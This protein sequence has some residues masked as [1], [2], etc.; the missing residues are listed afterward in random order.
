MN[1][2]PSSSFLESVPLLLC[3]GDSDERLLDRIFNTRELKAQQVGG[4]RNIRPA[5]AYLTR[6]NQPV[7]TIQDC[8]FRPL[9][10]AEECYSQNYAERHFMWRRHELENYLIEPR[11]VANCFKQLQPYSKV[12]L[13]DTEDSARHWIKNLAR[14]LLEDQAGRQTA[15]EL[16]RQLHN[17]FPTASSI[18][19]VNA[20]QNR[21]EWQNRL[22]N[23]M[24]EICS[25]AQQFGEF[26]QT[27]DADILQN[28]EANLQAFSE[29]NFLNIDGHL[30]DF[31]GREMVQKIHQEAY[32][33]VSRYGLREFQT[34][35]VESFVEEWNHDPSFLQPNDF[36]DLSAAI[37]RL[38]GASSR[39][40]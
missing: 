10:E 27:T 19:Q 37:R 1:L 8:D 32:I 30:K 35:L 14:D 17:T 31:G 5:A 15:W 4:A 33:N 21:E 3:E 9:S 36:A 38:T 6:Q 25:Q 16:G 2:P 13:P 7:F 28:Y 23:G 11:V 29:P 18:S 34:D 22:I 20:I 26:V 24:K 39:A 12:A 40:S